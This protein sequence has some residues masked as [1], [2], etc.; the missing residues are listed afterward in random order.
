MAGAQDE[1]SLDKFTSC[2]GETSLDIVSRA[3]ETVIG[4][5]EDSQEGGKDGKGGIFL[6]LDFWF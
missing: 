4:K 2:Q 6:I 5:R 1:C 3:I